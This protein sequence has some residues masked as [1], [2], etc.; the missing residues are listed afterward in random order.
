[1]VELPSD[2]LMIVLET[3]KQYGGSKVEVIAAGIYIDAEPPT[4]MMEI[5][6]VRLSH[7][8]WHYMSEMKTWAKFLV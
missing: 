6:R 4:H 7:Y 8:G 5:D 3:L 2:E 1:M